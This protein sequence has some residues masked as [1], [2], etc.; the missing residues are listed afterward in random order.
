MRARAILSARVSHHSAAMTTPLDD[1]LQAYR[2]ALHRCAV[3]VLDAC[4][5]AQRDGFTR[6]QYTTSAANA[7]MLATP[8]IVRWFRHHN[9]AVRRCGACDVVLEWRAHVPIADAD[10]HVAT[11]LHVDKPII[12]CDD[13][14]GDEERDK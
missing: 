2:I 9:I 14:G 10:P 8:S 6:H 3:G 13:D 5:R 11:L 1:A 12:E 7:H 4:R